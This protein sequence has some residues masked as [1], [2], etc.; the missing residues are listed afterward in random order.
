M[1]IYHLLLKK[2]SDYIVD[3]DHCQCKLQ[4]TLGLVCAYLMCVHSNWHS[5]GTCQPKVCQLYHSFIIDQQVLG[6]QV[7]MQNSAT[8]AEQNPL[9]DLIQVTLKKKHR[10]R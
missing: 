1:D 4:I 6:F 3:V 7:T 10:H 8:V 2:A 9:Q 5:E